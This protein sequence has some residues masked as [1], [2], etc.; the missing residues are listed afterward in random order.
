MDGIFIAHHNTKN[1]LGFEYLKSHQ[2]DQY[3]FG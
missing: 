2:M 1:L 3:I